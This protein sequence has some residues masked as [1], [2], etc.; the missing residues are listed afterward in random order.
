MGIDAPGASR[1]DPG[2]AGQPSEVI[3]TGD[4]ADNLK[5]NSGSGTTISQKEIQAAQ[6][7]SSGEILRH[8]PGVQIRTEDPMGLRL[9]IG[10]RGLSPARSRLVLV[11]EDGVPVVVSPYGEPELYYMTSVERI[12]KIDVLKGSDV[13]MHGP[14]TVGAVVRLHTYE[15]TDQPEWYVAGTAG[16]RGYGEG[17]ARY[18]GT[19]G[20]VGYVVQAFHKGGEGYRDMGFQMTDA[21]AK[22][23]F[24]TGAHGDLMAKIGFHDEF[25]RTTYTGL[26]D[27]LYERNHRADTV[28]PDDYFAIRRYEA[29]VQHE[30]RLSDHVKLR[31]GVFAYHMDFDLR[32]QDFDRARL[33]S[34]DYVRIPDPTGLFFRN[35]TSIRDRAYDVGGL[36]E[37]LEARGKIAGID[38][39]LT[40]GVR[41]MDDVARRKLS[42]GQFPKAQ[43]GDLDTDDQ[44]QI[45][46]LA[47]WIQDQLA[48]NDWTLLTPAFRLEHSISSQT[49]YR[50]ED[51]TQ[52]PHDVD[53][54]GTTSSTG[55]MPGLGLTVG[56]PSLSMFSSLYLGY[57]APRISQA[58]T[59]DGKDADLHAERSSNYELG[60]SGKVAKWLR[61][62]V[63]G[64]WINFDN[65]LVSN[66]PLSG[67]D[68]EF[69][70]GGRTRHLGVEGTAIFRAGTML[71][72]PVDVDL[73]AHY[74][75]V[76]AR[77][78]G[79]TFDGKAIPY[80]PANTAQT[81]L[82]VASHFGLSGQVAFSYVGA[83]YTDEENTIQPG[84]TGLDGKIDAY[85]VLDLGARYKHART[86]LALAATVKNVLDQIYI[87]DRLPNGIF[88]AGFRQLYVTLS[89]SPPQ[90]TTK[91]PL[92]SALSTARRSRSSG[93]RSGRRWSRWRAASSRTAGSTLTTASRRCSST[94]G[95]SAGCGRGPAVGMYLAL[96]RHGRFGRLPR[97]RDRA[98]AG[99]GRLRAHVDVCPLLRQDE[100]PQSLLP[101]SAALVGALRPAPDRRAEGRCPPGSSISFAFR[102]ASSTCS[103]GSASLARIGSF[104]PSRSAFGSRATSRCRSSGASSIAC[105]R[106]MPLAGRECSSI[107]RS[108]AFLTWK[109]TRR[110]A[111]GVVVV[112]H[113]LTSLMFHIRMFPWRM[114][115]NATLFFDPAWCRRW[116]KNAKDIALA[117]IPRWGLCALAAYAFFQ[118]AIPLRCLLYPGNTLWTEEGFR[119]AWKVMLVEKSGELEYT[120]V[121]PDGTRSILP[122]R[123]FLTPFQTRQ[124]STQPD[125]I[126]ELAHVIAADYD[127]RGKGPVQRLR[128]RAR[129]LQ[130]T[131]RGAADRSN[132]G[133][134]ARETTPS[135]R[136]AGYCPRRRAIHSSRLGDPSP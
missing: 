91:A 136:S 105:G 35:T 14:Q 52:A 21:F 102:S 101:W 65:Q 78:Q 86:G 5:N 46:G 53:I 123:Q 87:S 120:V 126:L 18:T 43:S 55:A 68:S 61:A 4:K 1:R 90:R 54:H 40:A 71:E 118:I 41:L 34:I 69:I 38:N 84:P 82:D 57:S 107:S 80:S 63:D 110:A 117:P 131:A 16:S 36:T 73:A 24:A 19:N 89:W 8:V 88:T 44:T 23:R 116:L 26:T 106:P 9:N 72:W 130:R 56:R 113:V 103:A 77:F 67:L 37:E 33:P 17:L 27:E 45:W 112:F 49:T 12:Q 74:T 125:M 85:T 25:A 48:F 50:I 66:N 51:N 119:F 3:V 132:R 96:R 59:P 98:A 99:R 79:G 129:R 62:E 32:L 31:S 121:E 133:S 42:T 111:Y 104:T 76:H 135:R 30:E 108:S 114:I 10:V 97:R 28:A 29:T 64:F 70:D 6:P 127:Q 22:A 93:W 115:I 124:A 122:A 58:I 128:E 7:E 2:R 100:L 75:Y 39:K 94:I 81:T 109:K 47:G 11:E 83:Q 13:L 60:V 95:D 92:S 134:R 20:D 15:P